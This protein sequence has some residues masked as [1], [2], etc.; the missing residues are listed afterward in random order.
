MIKQK[1]NAIIGKFG[2]VN[3]DVNIFFTIKK[4]SPML[5]ARKNIHAKLTNIKT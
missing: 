1:N 2:F 5:C 3:P 4:A